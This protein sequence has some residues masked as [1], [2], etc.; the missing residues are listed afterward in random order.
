[1]S[2]NDIKTDYLQSLYGIRTLTTQEEHDLA[3][4]I[5]AGDD[6]ALERLVTHN[7]RFVP[8]VVTKMTAWQH[9][10]TPLEDILAIGNEMLLIAARR[11]KP[12]KNVPFAGYARPFIERGVRRELDNTSNII[13]LPINVMEELK[14]MNYNEQALSQVLGRKPTVAEL[15]TIV[16]TTATRIHQ[17]KGYIS[18]EPISLDNLNNENLQEESEE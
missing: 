10:K 14:R 3:E 16:N 8:H 6:D 12:H 4:K 5:Q 18:R 17:L 13:R 9:G 7:L 1:L 2:E 15:A 11:W